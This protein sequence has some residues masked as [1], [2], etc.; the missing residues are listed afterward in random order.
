[1][2]RIGCL[3]SLVVLI[4]CLFALTACSGEGYVDALKQTTTVTMGSNISGGE[5]LITFDEPFYDCVNEL[6]VDSEFKYYSKDHLNYVV[7]TFR[8]PMSDGTYQISFAVFSEAVDKQYTFYSP[9]LS[10]I[11]CNGEKVEPFNELD[12]FNKIFGSH[13]VSSVAQ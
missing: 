11:V 13:I 1:M 10:K 6:S 9:H 8:V 3:T 5:Y 7:C 4:I 2:K 12:V